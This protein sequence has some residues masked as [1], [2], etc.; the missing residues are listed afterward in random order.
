M[1][2]GLVVWEANLGDG[3]GAVLGGTLPPG[4]TCGLG[5]G[6]GGTLGRAGGSLLAAPVPNLG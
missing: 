4:F 5:G 6:L 2:Y 3:L 1:A